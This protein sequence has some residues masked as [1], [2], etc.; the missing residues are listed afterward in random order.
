ML[1]LRFLS[2][3]SASA[4]AN[5]SRKP[6]HV[7]HTATLPIFAAGGLTAVVRLRRFASVKI[8]LEPA[9]HRH[10]YTLIPSTAHVCLSEPGRHESMEIRKHVAYYAP[11]KVH[12]VSSAN[13]GAR[14]MDMSNKW[15]PRHRILP[16]Y[17]AQQFP[18]ICKHRFFG[19]VTD[20][21][22][23]RKFTGLM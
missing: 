11:R 7:K 10:V 17:D 21:P 9:S 3:E 14:S 12:C 20:N 16:A 5:V 19:A 4:I 13:S 18:T 15:L 22:I 23:C 1:P 8:M 6:P 2:S